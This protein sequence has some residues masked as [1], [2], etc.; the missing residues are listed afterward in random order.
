MYTNPPND[1]ASISTGKLNNNKTDILYFIV[2]YYKDTVVNLN[3][4]RKYVRGEDNLLINRI[5]ETRAIFIEINL[6][7]IVD[8]SYKQRF[9]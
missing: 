6:K 1:I 9:Y 5:C 7:L 2:I 4:D 3:R 8:L